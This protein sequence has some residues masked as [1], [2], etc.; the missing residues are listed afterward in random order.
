MTLGPLGEAILR[1]NE[2]EKYP[3]L[4]TPDIAYPHQSKGR[5]IILI[6]EIDKAARDVPND[7]LNEFDNMEFEVPEIDIKVKADEALRPVLIIT[8]NSERNLPDAFMRRCVFYHIPFPGDTP[9]ASN[10]ER[11]KA[12]TDIVNARLPDLTRDLPEWLGDA[13]TLFFQ[14][15][16]KHRGIQKR[17]STAELLNWLL[18]LHH[19]PDLNKQHRV[20]DR[21]E[22]F[23][24]SLMTLLIKNDADRNVADRIFDA[25]T[26]PK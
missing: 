5:S 8:S 25:L 7:L 6:D 13:F 3:Q 10:E 26:T 12:I 23:R 4:P 17:P 2:P 18:M 20:K 21:P 15:R 19:Q 22:V 9:G 11:L 16:E 1:A 14:L 24:Q